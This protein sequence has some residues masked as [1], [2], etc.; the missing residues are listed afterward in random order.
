MIKTTS[1]ETTHPLLGVAERLSRVHLVVRVTYTLVV[2][3]VGRVVAE[4]FLGLLRTK[5]HGWVQ[6]TDRLRE[7][8]KHSQVTSG[9]FGDEYSGSCFE[10]VGFCTL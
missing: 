8:E 6:Y 2:H 9:F 10:A 1:T 5:C 3:V 7:K 4:I